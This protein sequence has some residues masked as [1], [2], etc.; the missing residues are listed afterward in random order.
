MLSRERGRGRG[1]EKEKH[2]CEREASIGCLPFV[3]GL[4]I[5][6]AWTGDQTVCI[7]DQTSNPGMCPDW[8]SNSQPLVYGMTLQPTESHW[9]GQLSFFF[10]FEQILEHCEEG[11]N[12]PPLP[13][14]NSYSWTNKTTKLTQ[15]W[16]NRRKTNTILVHRRITICLDHKN[17]AQGNNR[18]RYPF[19]AI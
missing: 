19:C 18:T 1:R 9:P 12:F 6:C 14:F 17:E 15:D 7:R 16:I 11:E 13:F 4:G 3:P 10:C 2:Q 5:T 8:E